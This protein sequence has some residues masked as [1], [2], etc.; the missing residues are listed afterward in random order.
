MGS[1]RYDDAIYSARV[2]TAAAAGADLF[3][4]DDAIRTGK[5]VAGVHES[6]DPKKLN[7][8]GKNIRE[9]LDSDAAPNSRAIAVL[10]DETGSMH[11]VPRL[12]AKKLE[13]LMA[14]L[15]K[16][17]FV[18]DPHI[19]FGGIGDAHS[20]KAPLQLGQF[21]GGNEI[22]DTLTNIYLESNGG[23]GEPQESYELAMYYI[24]RHT[25]CD[26]INKRAQKGYCNVPV[27]PV[28]MANQTFKRIGD[29][30]PGDVVMGWDKATGHRSIR[31]AKVQAMLSHCA[32]NVVEATLSS[33]KKIKCT[34]DHRWLSAY[35]KSGMPDVWTSVQY[36][37]GGN[38]ADRT[39]LGVLSRILNPA[40][41]I[42]PEYAVD[43]GWLAGIYDGEGSSNGIA[44]S[45]SH[46]PEVC[47]R[48]ERTL[49]L[50]G[51]EWSYHDD[52]Y[53]VLGGRDALLKFLQL[54]ITRRKQ[55]ERLLTES[56]WSRYTG[57]GV[58]P[59][60]MWGKKDHV[61]RVERLPA[62]EVISMQTETGNYT[63]WGYASSNC[64]ILGDERPYP[65]VK[66]TQV[67]ALIGDDLEADIPTKDIVAEVQKHWHLFW[68]MPGGTAHW[69]DDSVIEPNRK[70][71]GQNFILLENP[72]DVC[73]LIV[74]T[75]GV[76][77][78]YDLH[79]VGAALKDVGAD[80]GAISRSGT[81][82]ATYAKSAGL[83]KTATVSGALVEAGQ[84]DVSRL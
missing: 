72:D 83:A 58:Q 75:I 33:G 71:F 4:H 46:N 62:Q 49:D 67:K 34:E 63:A 19:M 54:P 35:R 6:L 61:I 59:L 39:R 30:T 41:G 5:A 51:F 56:K 10:F 29:I 40:E 37:Q 50:L 77:E 11:L 32:D 26:C 84:D 66:A 52:S 20:D 76:T 8:F 16:K 12:F 18:P 44:Q 68:I 82:L 22:D 78:G 36:K 13:K 70:M 31:P 65:A 2:S 81:A 28:W 9:S 80:A 69:H 42:P 64:F 3:V 43:A 38:R 25:D 24:A 1:S 60:R 57:S 55:I 73:E 14:S 7:T 15:V 17:A 47:A 23:G 21:E 53:F 45:R 27:A 48:I 74:S 79:D